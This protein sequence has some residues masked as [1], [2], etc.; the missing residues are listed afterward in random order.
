MKLRRKIFLWVGLGHALTAVFLLLFIELIRQDLLPQWLLWVIEIVAVLQVL[1]AVILVG[2][3]RRTGEYALKKLWN[4]INAF[5][6]GVGAF[7]VL[8]YILW[9]MIGNSA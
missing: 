1:G 9:E 4:P 2:T 7:A 5:W 6:T 8:P 3:L